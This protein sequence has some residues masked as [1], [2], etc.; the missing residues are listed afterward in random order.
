MNKGEQGGGG[1]K[2]QEPWMNIPFECP[3]DYMKYCLLA[4]SDVLNLC[5]SSCVN[6]FVFCLFWYKV[7]YS[8]Y[9]PLY[10]GK[11]YWV[12]EIL[13]S[14]LIELCF[15]FSSSKFW[16]SHSLHPVHI[17]YILLMNLNRLMQLLIKTER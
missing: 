3:I 12:F 14:N 2:T 4:M 1:V 16:I 6:Q 11:K 9:T 13:Y 17:K 10:P 15:V 7:C 8:W 5:E